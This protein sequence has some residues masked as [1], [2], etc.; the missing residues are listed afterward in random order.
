MAA[1]SIPKHCGKL[2]CTSLGTRFREVVVPQTIPTPRAKSQELLVRVRYAGINA[3]DINW[4]SGRYQPGIQPP[5]DT[6]FEGIGQIVEVGKD[7]KGFQLGDPV[8]FMH[9]GSFSEYMTLPQRRATLVPR[10]DPAYLSLLVSGCTASISL[11]RLGELKKGERV[12][13]TAAAGGTG[14]FAVQLA[15]LA[16]CH[17]IG[18]CSTD[19]KIDFLR[20]L[21]CDRPINYKNEDLKRVL[22][23]EYPS[24]VD[25]VYESVGGEMF[26]TCV[27]NLAVKGRVIVIGYI[28]SYQESSYSARPPLPLHQILLARSASVRGFFLN[29][30]AS[31]IPSHLSRLAQ[32]YEEGRVRAQVDMGEGVAGGPFKGLEGVYNGVDYLH[33]GRS[34][35]KVVV[36]V[37]TAAADSTRAKL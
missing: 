30:F 22:R 32:L 18:T 1:S 4:T 28:D 11:Q 35:G 24:G 21:G 5:F 23:E 13:V 3:S 25:V 33:S 36:E 34:S 6:G 16:G 8:V 37:A 20:S 14:Q 29:S 12:L 27:K 7:C 17:V 9:A 15:K 2:V 19:E 10:E 26:S 31:E